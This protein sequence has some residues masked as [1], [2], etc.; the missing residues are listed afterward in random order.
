MPTLPLGVRYW[1]Y[2][3]NLIIEKHC[4]GCN[5]RTTETFNSTNGKYYI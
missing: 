4:Y 5:S 2:K 1:G 3:Q